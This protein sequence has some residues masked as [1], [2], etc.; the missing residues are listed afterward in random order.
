M[1]GEVSFEDEGSG[2]VSASVRRK[3][4]K[5]LALGGMAAVVSS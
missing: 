1:L 2:S 5:R 4:L 3:N